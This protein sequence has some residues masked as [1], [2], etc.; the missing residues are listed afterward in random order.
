MPAPGT[1][2]NYSFIKKNDPNKNAIGCCRRLPPVGRSR[3]LHS[4]LQH[5][6][7]LAQS[8]CCVQEMETVQGLIVHMKTADEGVA[9]RVDEM[10]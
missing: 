2:I 4:Q 6:R 5:A 7:H 9:N 1:V 3:P 10:A 8:T